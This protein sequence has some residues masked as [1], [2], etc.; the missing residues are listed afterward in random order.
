[1]RATPVIALFLSILT[2]IF[3]AEFTFKDGTSIKASIYEHPLYKTSSKGL[4]LTL[5]NKI[6]IHHYPSYHKETFVDNG[7]YE[8]QEEIPAPPSPSMSFNPPFL[9]RCA[10]A[11]IDFIYFS[12]KTLKTLHKQYSKELEVEKNKK[13]DYNLNE[14]MRMKEITSSIKKAYWNKEYKKATANSTRVWQS[15]VIKEY[16]GYK[17]VIWGKYVHEGNYISRR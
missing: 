12:S 4:L 10:P 7:L 2:N 5:D 13:Y 16:S 15:R 17:N 1:M 14:V 9:P 8:E 11:R 6:Y 3:G